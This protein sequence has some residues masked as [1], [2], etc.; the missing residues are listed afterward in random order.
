MSQPPSTISVPFWLLVMITFSGTLALNLFVPGLPDAAHTFDVGSA[1]MQMTITVYI[2]GLACGQLIYGPLSDG[3]GRR[4]MLLA[5]LSLYTLAGFAAA[6]AVGVKTLIAAR[7]LQALGGCA[8]LTLGR[9][10]LIS[11]AKPEKIVRDLATLNLVTTI[12]SGLAPLLGSWLTLWFGWR[13]ILL[14]IA[15]LGLIT[16]LFTW[17]LLPE[18]NRPTGSVS[19]A[20]V[21]RDYSLLLRSRSFMGFTLS[22]G[23]ATSSIYCF[24]VAAPFIFATQLHRPLHEFGLYMGVLVV[25]YSLGTIITRHLNGLVNAERLLITSYLVSMACAIGLLLISLFGTLTVLNLMI[26]MFGLHFAAGVSS[27]IAMA[28]A[29]EVDSKHMGSASGLLGFM[30]MSVGALATAAVGL[31]TDAALGVAVILTAA[32]VAGQIGI[33]V[34][35]KHS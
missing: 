7:L 21:T 12:G 9:V 35:L 17:R 30:Q 6:I 29:L 26:C 8:A 33:W 20:A 23:C 11:A 28:K 34:G 32:M 22:G 15:A 18:T 25:S 10:I 24:V 19:F 14:L 3:L 13:S 5:G 16:V 2:V 31:F 27:P 4:R 1:A